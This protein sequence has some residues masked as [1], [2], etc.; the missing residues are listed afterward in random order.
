MGLLRSFH[1]LAMTVL[2]FYRIYMTFTNGV[3]WFQKGVSI[4]TNAF[5]SGLDQPASNYFGQD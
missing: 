1:F 5:F 3:T 2:D 4:F